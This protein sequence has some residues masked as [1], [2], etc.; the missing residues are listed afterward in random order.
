MKK[1][2]KR[3]KKKRKKRRAR[4]RE[5]KK[6]FT[7]LYTLEGDC[8]TFRQEKGRKTQ[9]QQRQRW[10]LR[11]DEWRDSFIALKSAFSKKKRKEDRE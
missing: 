9:L 4:R 10:R 5:K 2:K 8:E 6:T 3:K 11:S 1:K 7:N